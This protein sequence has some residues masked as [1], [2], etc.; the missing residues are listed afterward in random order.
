MQILAGESFLI[1]L[2]N[3][4][5]CFKDKYLVALKDES[6]KM[7]KSWSQDILEIWIEVYAITLN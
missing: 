6:L 5:F 7:M 1:L 2:K 3:K 4:E